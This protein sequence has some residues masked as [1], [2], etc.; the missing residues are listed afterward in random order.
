MCDARRGEKN[1]GF[2]VGCKGF[3]QRRLAKKSHRLG[4]D[5]QIAVLPV[6][7]PERNHVKIS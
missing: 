3:V 6:A 2:S 1:S 5:E 4:W 7:L